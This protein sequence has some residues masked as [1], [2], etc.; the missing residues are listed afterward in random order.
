LS[1]P[2]YAEE[3]TGNRIPAEIPAGIIDIAAY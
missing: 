3:L 1:Q 2:L